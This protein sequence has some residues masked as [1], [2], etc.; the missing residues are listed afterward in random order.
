M[1]S[2]SLHL[3][4][5]LGATDLAVAIVSAAAGAASQIPKSRELE[6]QKNA[7][8]QEVAHANEALLSVSRTMQSFL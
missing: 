5:E 4:P 7:L 3:I 2:P 8:Q 1:S 6:E